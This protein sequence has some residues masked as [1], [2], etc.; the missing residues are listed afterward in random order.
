MSPCH[1]R[2]AKAHLYWCHA[3]RNETVWGTERTWGSVKRGVVR[4]GG[5]IVKIHYILAQTG[6]VQSQKIINWSWVVAVY[7]FNLSS[8]EAVVGKS[9]NSKPALSTKGVP[10]Q[11][12]LLYGET[13][14]SKTKPNQ[15]KMLLK[16]R[17]EKERLWNNL[18]LD[19]KQSKMS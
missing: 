10:G 18:K 3:S 1:Y 17:R 12:K 16:D 14:S 6:L 9:L 5:N 7:T 11:P 13:L 19:I 8:R 2:Y 4:Y 15:I